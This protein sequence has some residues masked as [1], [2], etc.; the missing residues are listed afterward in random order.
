MDVHINFWAVVLATVGAMVVGTIWYAPPVFGS[1]WGK[2]T[3]GGQRPRNKGMARP[4]IITIIVCLVT[5]YV[6][7]Y[8]ASMANQFYQGG[9]LA[10]TLGTALLLWLGFSAT[11]LVAHDAFESRPTKLTALNMGNDLA[12]LLVMGLIIGL[13]GA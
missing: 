13:I 4:M 2:L 1:V 5:A 3:N 7:A 12:T 11:R 9:F 6:L 10:N 8:F